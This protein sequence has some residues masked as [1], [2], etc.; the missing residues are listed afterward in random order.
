[1]QLVEEQGEDERAGAIGKHA[2]A[3]GEDD[4]PGISTREP[5]R[6]ETGFLIG[7][8]LEEDRDCAHGFDLAGRGVYFDVAR[9]GCWAIVAVVVVV[10]VVVVGE[11]VVV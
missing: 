5:E 10:V 2:A 4:E 3:S 7:V 6:G 11:V 9:V 8:F 1:M